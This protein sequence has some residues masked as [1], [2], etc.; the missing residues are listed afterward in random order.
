M[1][2]IVGLTGGI[3]SGKTTVAKLF[4]KHGVPIYIADERARLLMERPDVVEAV[5]QIFTTSVINENGLLDRAKI[6]QL[7]F[8]NKTLLEQLNQVV[9]PRVKKDFEDWLEEHKDSPFVI[10]ESAILFESGLETSCDL[11]ILVVAP[12][13]VRIER[14][15]ARDGVSKD[16]VLKIIDNQMKDEEKVGRSQYIIENNNK[17]TVESDIIAIIRDINLKNHLI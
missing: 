13:E 3:G 16:Q 15:M 7:V 8:D 17:K 4:Q 1:S 6:K 2:I 14:V 5:Q 10:K 12:E 9:H 11:V